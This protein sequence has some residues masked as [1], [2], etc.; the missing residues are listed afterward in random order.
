MFMN[1]QTVDGTLFAKMLSGGVSLLSAHEREL[2]S[3]NVFPVSDGDT[4]SNMLK[5]VRGGTA[6]IERHNSDGKICTVSSL[7]AKGALLG[8]L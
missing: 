4:G 5:T 7:F 3:L 1:T 6:E 8:A 2:N